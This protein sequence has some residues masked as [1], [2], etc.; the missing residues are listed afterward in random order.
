MLDTL[1]SASPT[2]V[3]VF[4]LIAVIVFLVA[5]FIAFREKTVWATLICVGLAC[6]SAAVIFLA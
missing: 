5:G 6:V 4:S 3:Q 1:V 2:A